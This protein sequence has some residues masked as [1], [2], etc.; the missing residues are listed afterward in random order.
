MQK[1]APITDRL[2]LAHSEREIFDAIVAHDHPF[3]ALNELFDWPILFAPL[4]EAYS[5]TGAPGIPLERGMKALLVQFWEDYSDREMER[6]LKENIAVRFFC[7]FGLTEE[8]PDFSYFSKLRT[9]LG[10]ERIADLFKAVNTELKQ[11]GLF[12]NFFAFIDASAII[13]KTALWSERDHAIALGA[14]KL[15]NLNVKRYAADTDA[16]FG[17]KGKNKIWYG[18]KRHEAV[19][20]RHGLVLRV[21]TTPA[22][23]PDFKVAH[24]IAPKEGAVFMDKLYDT[25]KT[26]ALLTARGLH[27]ATIRKNT[28]PSKDRDLDRWRSSVRMPF[29]GTFSKRRK[30][31]KFRSL[32]KVTMQCFLEAIVHNLKKAVTLLTPIPISP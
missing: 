6:C 29:E 2:L 9:R 19:D 1:A 14:K 25:K 28:N 18:Y 8:T 7:G 16:R 21:A 32:L 17:A 10:T 12:G 26:E 22:N 11:R 15:N 27:P 5:H 3:R 31:A 13:T 20:M 4:A 30:R 23:V 24:R